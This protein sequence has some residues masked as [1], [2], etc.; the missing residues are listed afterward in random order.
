MEK[1]KTKEFPRLLPDLTLEEL[2]DADLPPV[3]EEVTVEIRPVISQQ[4]FE[5]TK[6]KIL[7]QKLP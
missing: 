1:E 7:Q 6:E 5:K 2:I 4:E 3:K